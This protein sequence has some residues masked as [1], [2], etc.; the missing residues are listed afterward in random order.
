MK[1]QEG[2][3]DALQQ[4]NKQIVSPKVSYL[5]TED[6]GYLIWV[7]TAQQRRRQ[8]DHRLNDADHDRHRNSMAKCYDRHSLQ[9]Y[10]R[11]LF[12]DGSQH[13]DIRNWLNGSTQPRTAED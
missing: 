5:V 1:E 3:N 7:E 11:T 12:R 10:L 4:I 9:A 13:L 8:Q 2:F 6:R